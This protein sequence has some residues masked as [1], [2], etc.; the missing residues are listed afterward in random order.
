LRRRLLLLTLLVALVVAVGWPV[1]VEPQRETAD[2]ADPADA[3]LALG[4]NWRTARVAVRMVQDGEA[5]HAVLSDPYQGGLSWCRATPLPPDRTC[6]VPDP[7]TTRGEA[8]EIAR[9]ARAHHWDDVIVLAPTFHVSR[10][11]F[12]VER[13]YTGGLRMVDAGV[14]IPW[15]MWVYQ[16]GY[17]TAGYAKALLQRGC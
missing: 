8:R 15:W 5:R 6:F 16:Y 10:A 9:L 4:G 3:V 11:R 13:C 2:A 7:S 14:G 12:V 17:Q 1:Y